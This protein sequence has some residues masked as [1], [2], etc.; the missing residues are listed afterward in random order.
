MIEQ[1]NNYDWEEAFKIMGVKTLDEA[2]NTDF[3]REDVV[4]IYG[5]REGENDGINWLLFGRLKDKRYFFLSG[6]CCYT[7]W[8]CQGYCSVDV[9]LSKKLLISDGLTDEA[10]QVFGIKENKIGTIKVKE[11]V[12][13]GNVYKDVV[14]PKEII[15]NKEKI[16]ND[17]E[18]L[19]N[20]KEQI[21]SDFCKKFKELCDKEKIFDKLI[22]E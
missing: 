12:D 16:L 2:F 13:R 5:I 4:K 22:G 1:L 8:D 17:K 10:R 9:A 15:D 21:I 11:A 7:C 18:K 20:K 6:G 14:C 3:G 19:L